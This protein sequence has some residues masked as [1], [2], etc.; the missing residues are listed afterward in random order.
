MAGNMVSLDV[1]Y[2]EISFV[3]R[4]HQERSREGASI[5]QI[6]VDCD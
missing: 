1:A 3:M 2:T 5:L 6:L 4:V